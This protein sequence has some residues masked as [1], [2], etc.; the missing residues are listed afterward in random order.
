MDVLDRQREVLSMYTASGPQGF[1]G[2]WSRVLNVCLPGGQGEV[3]LFSLAPEEGQPPENSIS[4]ETL[5]SLTGPVL[6]L[7]PVIVSSVERWREDKGLSQPVFQ[8]LH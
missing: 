1:L 6:A 2:A 3:S 5:S 8:K 4:T 7:D